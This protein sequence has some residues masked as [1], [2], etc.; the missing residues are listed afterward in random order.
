MAGGIY[1]SPFRPYFSWLD[2]RWRRLVV[3]VVVGCCRSSLSSSYRLQV[4]GGQIVGVAQIADGR[5][6]ANVVGVH[7]HKY[8][9]KKL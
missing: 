9:E 2:R 7:L 4:A 6:D 5:N 1:S 8:R 3:V